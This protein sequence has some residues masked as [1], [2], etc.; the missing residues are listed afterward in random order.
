M[1]QKGQFRDRVPGSTRDQLTIVPQGQMTRAVTSLISKLAHRPLDVVTFDGA[2]PDCDEPIED[3]QASKQQLFE[4]CNEL[5]D[6]SAPIP[7]PPTPPPGNA[8]DSVP[9]IA[10]TTPPITTSTAPIEDHVYI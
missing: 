3:F 5:R 2:A 1:S 9:P 10:P 6:G 8:R 7:D 4:F